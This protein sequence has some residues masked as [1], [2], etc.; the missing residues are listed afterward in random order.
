MQD[1]LGSRANQSAEDCKDQQP[2]AAATVN[3]EELNDISQGEFK[4]E[5]L[6]MKN[7]EAGNLLWESKEWDLNTSEEVKVE[8]PAQMLS[9]RAIGREIVFYSKKI[10]HEFSIRQ[11]MTLHGQVVEEYG[12]N[13]GFVMPNTTNSWEQVIDAEVGQVMPAEV[14]SG[15]LIVDTYFCVKGVSFAHQRYHIIYV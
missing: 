3:I 13:F 4:I 9:C 7:A 11:V 14:L 12:F 8:F 15:N 1:V 10:M 5:A 2:A 6:R